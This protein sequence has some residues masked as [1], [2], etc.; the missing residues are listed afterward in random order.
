[1]T[2]TETE[3]PN[4]AATLAALG[5]T[6]E[7]VFVPFS[8]SRNA[9]QETPNLNWLVTIKR[10]GR[11]VLR[12]DFMAGQGHAPAY[13]VKTVPLNFRPRR[14]R[15]RSKTSPSGFTYRDATAREA[16]NQYRTEL[17]AAE[18]ESGFKMRLTRWG[19][20]TKFETVGGRPASKNSRIEPNPV[21]VLYSLVMDSDV[22]DSGGFE[23][24]AENFGYDTDSRAAE[25]IYKACVDLALKMR[26]AF[27][28]DGMESLA[29][30]FQDY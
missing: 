15:T 18:C 13:Q 17:A 6:V 30:A 19:H 14:Y 10:D 4:P 24:W 16:L 29:T 25:S 20:E 7:S 8:R 2:M 28:P 9:G 21:D 22:L 12:T 27:G 1:M 5:V 26:A 23:D 11:E 3:T